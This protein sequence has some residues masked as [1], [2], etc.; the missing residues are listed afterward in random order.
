MSTILIIIIALIFEYF[1]D[2][3]KKFR[4]DEILNSIRREIGQ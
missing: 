3:I 1:Y 2:D 4:E